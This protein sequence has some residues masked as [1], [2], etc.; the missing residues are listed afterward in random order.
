MG[1]K[2]VKIETDSKEEPLSNEAFKGLD[3]SGLSLSNKVIQ[4]PKEPKKE[5]KP[6][7]E[8]KMGKL[9]V[10]REKGGRGGKTVT[11]IEGFPTHYRDLEGLLKR[12]KKECGVGGTLKEGDVLEIQGDKRDEIAKILSREGFKVVFSGG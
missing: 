12:M 1:R 6:G 7:G 9:Y 10:R 8:K 2:K 5:E 4:R 11:V 3:F